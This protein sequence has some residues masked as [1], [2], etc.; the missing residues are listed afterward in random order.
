MRIGINATIL[1]DKPTGLGT[2]TINIIN[3]LAEVAG[4]EAE[5]I[6]YTS[7][8]EYFS[9][10]L[11]VRKVTSE[12]RPSKGKVGAIKRLLWSQFVLPN[13]LKEDKVEVLYSTTHHGIL[14]GNI[15]QIITVHDILP[16]K[17]PNQYRLQNLYFKRVLPIILKNSSKVVTVSENTKE[18]LVNAYKFD[19]NDIHVVYNSFEKDHYSSDNNKTNN[20]F[21]IVYDKYFLFVGA[22]FPHKNLKR[23]IE[24][25]L[26]SNARYTHKLLI[27]GNGKDY[28]SDVKSHFTSKQLS[29]VVFLD[30][31]KYDEL[32]QLYSGAT[33]L[34]YSS[35]YEGFG[36]PPLE[37]MAS[38]CP[39]IA[40][41]SSSIP[42]VC[43]D[44]V[45]YCNPNKK[46]DFVEAINN[47]LSSDILREGLI[48]KGNTRIKQFD[49]INSAKKL[50]LVL[51]GSK[52]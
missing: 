40:S 39:V 11:T 35:F 29:N 36:I 52:K 50:L 42:E 3:K 14:F 28:I 18:D 48:E 10:R 25:F 6:V 47:I 1:D 34:L 45:L 23:T 17:F 8:P 16:L 44:A 5:I 19:N 20:S 49:W 24:A 33:A 12:L 41:N 26:E 9:H 31:V 13:R 21:N 37:A 38:N 27:T 30:Y 7:T 2:Y 46:E 22:T 4:S 43:G 51:G 32:P 15:N